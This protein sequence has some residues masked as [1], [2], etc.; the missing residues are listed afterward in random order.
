MA[1]DQVRSAETALPGDN[2]TDDFAE[3]D[4][5]IIAQ[6]LERMGRNREGA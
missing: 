2:R 4:R 3:A 1:L 5:R 6:V